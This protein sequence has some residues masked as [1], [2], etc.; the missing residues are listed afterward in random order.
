[1]SFIFNISIILITCAFFVY[2]FIV[3]IFNPVVFYYKSK[4]RNSLDIFY[5]KILCDKFNIKN[6]KIAR[7]YIISMVVFGYVCIVFGV[8]RVFYIFTKEST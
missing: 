7:I 2:V 4:N 1:M 6:E 3:E 8:V 5:S